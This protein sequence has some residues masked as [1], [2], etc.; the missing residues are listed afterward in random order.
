M[1]DDPGLAVLADSPF[2]A[3][4]VD[5]GLRVTWVN[6]VAAG[7][8]GTTAEAAIGRGLDELARHPRGE[9]GW[10]DRLVGDGAV[11][12]VIA[13]LRDDGEPLRVAWQ[14]QRRDD[15]FLLF[16]HDAG[17]RFDEDLKLRRQDQL[18]RTIVH[19]LDVVV[20]AVDPRGIFTYH[21][22]KALDTAGIPQGA[23][24]GKD[25]FELYA[26]LDGNDSIRRAMQSGQSDHNI[27][28]AHG[29][30]WEHWY[31]PVRD[32]QGSIV[33]AA[34]VSMDVTAA[35]HREQEM[36]ER[37]ALIERQQAV[38]RELSTPIIEVWD[39]VL[40]VPMVG[41]VDSVRADA[42]MEDLLQAVSGKRAR[43]AVLDLTGIDALD[44]STAGALV[45]LIRA[46]RLL[47]AEGIVTGIHPSVAQTLVGLDVD[48]RAIPVF[49][50]LRS[51]LRHC[52]SRLAV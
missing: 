2:G 51:A 9:V 32:E 15:G 22:G 34:G 12:R 8:L 45:G 29:M 6:A 25:V 21:E 46:L 19:N 38:I 14:H 5:A 36:E 30:Y 10:R 4:A 35:K 23:F 52:I 11:T 40:C 3:I 7:L 28:P 48:L 13:A 16:A 43:F 47:G 31:L 24:I 26:G 37:L 20:W 41:L 49:G 50:N 33:G 39:R 1:S 44:T 27:T 42:I 18:L 17:A